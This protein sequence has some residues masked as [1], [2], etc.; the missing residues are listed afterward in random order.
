MPL[1]S[2]WSK[3]D[4]TKFNEEK[5]EKKS[6][7]PQ[8]TINEPANKTPENGADKIEI[9]PDI[10]QRKEKAREL[11]KRYTPKL[12]HNNP[13]AEKR[14]EQLETLK[15]E[16]KITISEDLERLELEE[17]PDGYTPDYKIT[18]SISKIGERIKSIFKH[19]FEPKK[20]INKNSDRA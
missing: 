3:Y 17:N 7:I 12:C 13:N 6:E 16:N 14:L 5:Q 20:E 9:E 10:E 11:V 8:D 15:I 19:L 1:L 18:D 2:E 4:H